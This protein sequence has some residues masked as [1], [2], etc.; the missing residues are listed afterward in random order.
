MVARCGGEGCPSRDRP[1]GNR[2]PECPQ[3]S[4]SARRLPPRPSS[5]SRRPSQERKPPQAETALST[6]DLRGPKTQ[7]HLPRLSIRPCPLLGRTAWLT[8]RSAR[9][10]ATAVDLGQGPPAL[11]VRQA[12]ATGRPAS[13]PA[14]PGSAPGACRVTPAPALHL[15]PAWTLRLLSCGSRF[16]PLELRPTPAPIPTAAI[17]GHRRCLAFRPQD[18]RGRSRRSRTGGQVASRVSSP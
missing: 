14:L 11:L 3:P 15:D 5:S 13:S 4:P 8:S 2:S 6:S 7:G 16:Y 1:P 17:L 12:P 18:A 9:L 10:E